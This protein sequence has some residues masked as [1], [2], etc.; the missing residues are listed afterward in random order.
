MEVIRP[1]SLHPTLPLLE[2]S[3]SLSGWDCSIFLS[4][5]DQRYRGIV[6]YHQQQSLQK[7]VL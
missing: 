2:E 5:P 4:D 1:I 7:D 3:L 6:L